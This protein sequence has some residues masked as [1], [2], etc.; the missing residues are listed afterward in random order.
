MVCGC[1]S[2]MS[3]LPS[4]PLPPACSAMNEAGLASYSSLS[5][6]PG[7]DALAGYRNTPPYIRVRWKSAMNVPIYLDRHM[8]STEQYKQTKIYE[9]EPSCAAICTDKLVNRENVSACNY[10][11]RSDKP[12]CLS[13]ETIEKTHWTR[14]VQTNFSTAQIVHLCGVG[15]SPLFFLSMNSLTLGSQE[16]E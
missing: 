3:P 16:A 10:K 14:T 5:L 2:S 8:D 6:P 15:L 9:I 7:E 4:E 13:E 12:P 1:T 11:G